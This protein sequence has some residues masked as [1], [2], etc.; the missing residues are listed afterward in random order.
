[1]KEDIDLYS[2][3]KIVYQKAKSIFGNNID[4]KLSTRKDKKYMILNDD[5]KWVHFGEMGYEDYTKH[6]DIERLINFKKRKSKW[7]NAN[8]YSP[9]FLS[10]FLLW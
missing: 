10:Y 8:K 9:A 4:I 1:M 5:N 3:P 7:K 2:N 6:N